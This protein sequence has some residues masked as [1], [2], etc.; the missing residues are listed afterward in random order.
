MNFK[1]VLY[2][3]AVGYICFTIGFEVAFKLMNNDSVSING[4]RVKVVDIMYTY[5]NEQG[6]TIEG[7]Y[8]LVSDNGYE[9][10]PLGT[11]HK[12]YQNAKIRK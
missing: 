10:N 2:I 1:K 11:Y 12:E 3:V 7:D 4:N 6:E 5:E 9:Y 8:S